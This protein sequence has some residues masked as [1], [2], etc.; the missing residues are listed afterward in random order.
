MSEE[1][2][3]LLSPAFA[4]E[5]VPAQAD[6]TGNRLISPTSYRLFGKDCP[7]PVM[8][9]YERLWTTRGRSG[10]AQEDGDL[11]MGWVVST[12][13]TDGDSDLGKRLHEALETLGWRSRSA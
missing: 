11:L 8:A 7:Q 5:I 1:T 2:V 3:Y 9:A 12:T 10:K 6:A 13:L 4:R